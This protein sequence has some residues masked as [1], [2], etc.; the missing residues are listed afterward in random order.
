[1]DVMFRYGSYQDAVV[2]KG[3]PLE[4]YAPH[5]SKGTHESRRNVRRVMRILRRKGVVDAHGSKVGC[6]G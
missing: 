2:R 4:F 5:F 3:G 1:V 6:C